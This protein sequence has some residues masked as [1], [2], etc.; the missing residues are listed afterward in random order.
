MIVVCNDH[1]ERLYLPYTVGAGSASVACAFRDH[2]L[3]D[4]IGFTYASWDADA[5]AEDFV[6]RLAEAGRRFGERTGGEDALIPIILD[7]ENAWEH[8]EGGGRPFLRSLY[9][10]LSSHPDVQTVTMGEACR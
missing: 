5:A 4:L 1:P 7:G 8:F 6:G 2:V 9:R 3:S 10:R